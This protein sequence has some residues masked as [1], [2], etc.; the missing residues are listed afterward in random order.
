MKWGLVIAG[1]RIGETTMECLEEQPARSGMYNTLFMHRG[2]IYVYP[3]VVDN[4]DAFDVIQV[5]MSPKDMT[6]IPLLRNLIDKKGSS[7]K[8]VLNNDYVCEYWGKWGLDPFYFENMQKLGDFVYGTEPFQVSNMINGAYCLP[9]PTNTEMLKKFR[10][11]LPKENGVGFI[12]HWWSGETY[13]P[14]RLLE[15]A[16]KKFGVKSTVFGYGAGDQMEK[17]KG[18]MWDN[19]SGLDHFPNYAEKVM[20]QRAMY[21]PCQYHTYGRNG[22][23]MAC[24]GIPVVGSNRVF[25]YNKLFPELV[26]DPYN[27]KDALD[28]L[29][30]AL[31]QP[32]RVKEIMA[33]A[34]KDV[35]YFSYDNCR[36]RWMTAFNESIER[37]GQKWYAKN[38]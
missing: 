1:K 4:I 30:I 5:N 2:G 31:N 36:Q 33:K 26:C 35:E 34:Y 20:A 38:G 14:W 8:L 37:G 24:F 23:E 17:F 6:I 10:S 29:D 28:K 9:H 32:E 7:T 25:S 27:A 11:D 3:E 12:Y 18:I 22:V 15:Q 19:I 21:D 16:K 13:L